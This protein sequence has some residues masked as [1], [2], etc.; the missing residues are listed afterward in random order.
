MT[1][2]MPASAKELL[3][4]IAMKEDGGPDIVIVSKKPPKSFVPKKVNL[5]ELSLQ[6]IHPE[7]IARQLTL[8]EHELFKAIQTQEMMKQRWIKEKKNRTPNIHKMINR[9]NEVSLW[10]ASEIV[11]VEDLKTR[12]IV[13]NRF[14]FIAQ[15]CFELNN[16]NAVMEIL[17][18]LNCS[19]VHRLKQTWELLPSKSLEVYESLVVLMNSEGNFNNYRESL[20]KARAPIVPYLGLTLTDLVF[21]SEGNT[22]MMQENPKL[23]NW[24]KLNL[25]GNVIKEVQSFQE[26]PYNLEKVE[27]IQ[28][29]LLSKNKMMTEDEMYQMSIQREEKVPKRRLKLTDKSDSATQLPGM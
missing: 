23:I 28:N 27:S 14:I 17:S 9:F 5:N 29:Y 8:I 15:K 25:I 7:E 20:K 11:R 1:P 13:L 21:I 16:F 2:S 3:A 6:D 19:S 10:V 26:T 18:A 24:W 4:L 12:A 22:D